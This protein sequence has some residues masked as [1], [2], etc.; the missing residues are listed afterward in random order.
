VAVTIHTDEMAFQLVHDGVRYILVLGQLDDSRWNVR[1][2][3]VAAR[4]GLIGGH[5][6]T[7]GAWHIAYEAGL[8]MARELIQQMPLDERICR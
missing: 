4:S 5:V 8:S 1:L 2:Q 7:F 3:I 6:G